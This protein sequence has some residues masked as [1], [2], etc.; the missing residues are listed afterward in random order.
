MQLFKAN[1]IDVS[2]LK[3]NSVVVTDSCSTYNIIFHSYNN[4]I[5][6]TKV[7]THKIYAGILVAINVKVQVGELN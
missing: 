1:F 4:I 7:R 3:L 6:L 5:D 2:Y